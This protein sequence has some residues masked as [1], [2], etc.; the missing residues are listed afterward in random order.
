MTNVE[1]KFC[2]HCGKQINKNAKICIHCGCEV[3][4]L[5]KQTI[6]NNSNTNSTMYSNRNPY[7]NYGYGRVR[8]KWVAFFLCLFLGIFG[9]HKFYEGKT[10]LGILYIFTFGLFGF[11]WIFDLI[12]LFSKPNP[13]IVYPNRTHLY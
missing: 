7:F 9:A 2:Q 1:T 8:N 3:E 5:E 11:G 10:A 12:S 4:P 13:Y 6:I